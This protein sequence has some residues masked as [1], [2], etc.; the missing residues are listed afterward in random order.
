M[1]SL[2]ISEG[3]GRKKYDGTS[4]IAHEI[5]KVKLYIPL[6]QSSSSEMAFGVWGTGQER[7]GL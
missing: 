1:P 3:M 5:P 7:R 4:S 6:F 2:V